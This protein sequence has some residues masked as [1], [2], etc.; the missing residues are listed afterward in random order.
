MGELLKRLLLSPVLLAELLILSLIVNLL[1]LA[2]PLFV[3][4]VLQRYITSGVD[5]TLQT[6]V[7]GVLIAA[8]FEFLFRNI[9]HRVAR[10]FDALN[11]EL[12]N[13]TLEKLHTTKASYFSVRPPF[14]TDNIIGHLNTLRQTYSA[15]NMI[16]FLDL[17]FVAI[18]VIAIFFLSKGLGIIC[19]LILLLPL[20]LNDMVYPFIQG[21]FRKILP[22]QVK[23][24]DSLRAITSRFDTIRYF[25][26]SK[27]VIR[28]WEQAVQG[29]MM[30]KEKL[31]ARKHLASSMMQ[32]LG[33]IMTV[34]IIGYGATL[35][36][37]NL[38]TVSA[39]IGANI[40]AA[41]A[42][43]SVIKFSSLKEQF[44]QANFALRE[45]KS[46][47][48]FPP[49]S[50]KA[51]IS[52]E[53][54]R[55]DVVVNDLAYQYPDTKNPVF[56]GLHAKF[57]PGQL[58]AITGVNASGKSTLMKNFISLLE[59]VRGNIQVD[60]IEIT[61]LSI[62]WWRENI[63]YLPQEPQ[64]ISAT[65]R[66]NI[67][68]HHEED[69]DND[70]INSVIASSDL[71]G[72]IQSHP[73]GIDMPISQAANELSFG[74]K[75][76]IALARALVNDCKLVFLDEPTESLDARGCQQ[77]Y[78]TLQDLLQSEKTVVIA[79][80]DPQIIQ[81]ASLVID[82]NQKPSPK[83]LNQA[84]QGGGNEIIEHEENS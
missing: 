75:K 44:D 3:M 56:V 49:E 71:A 18:F 38:L 52:I 82:M 6:L 63:S 17:P 21:A 67:F 79:T 26:L 36:V 80:S 13:K 81:K 50:A 22:V 51:S 2:S 46:I 61:Q 28:I 37:E 20:I 4:Q 15:A 33:V 57:Q 73:D 53:D 5:S 35:A 74:I 62:E 59:P 58:S 39:L 78:Q 68:G 41:R 64:F 42:L 84:N 10:N 65:L 23:K 72:F 12:E 29:M 1:A 45:I 54:C 7:F 69:L 24:N 34:A 60:G 70:K 11:F 83:I 31:D 66:D 30:L 32:S 19:L 76:R 14:A 43:S 47:G 8:L 27:L 9:R 25:R 16:I 55:G 48:Q 77:I 40:L